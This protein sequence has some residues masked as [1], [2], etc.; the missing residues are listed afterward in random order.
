MR[1]G[2]NAAF[3]ALLLPATSTYDA[4]RRI[5]LPQ[6]CLETDVQRAINRNKRGISRSQL[7]QTLTTIESP[8]L[9]VQ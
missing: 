6:S 2:Q 1:N 7:S 3:S 4:F 5:R 8:N 9:L